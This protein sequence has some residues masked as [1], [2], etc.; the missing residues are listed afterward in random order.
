MIKRRFLVSAAAAAL[1]CGFVQASYA[2]ASANAPVTPTAAATAAAAPVTAGIHAPTSEWAVGPISAAGGKGAGY[3]SM[4]NSYPTGQTVVFAS[5]NQGSNSIALDFHKNLFDEGTQYDVKARVGSVTR[6]LEALAA[7]NQVLVM[8]TGIDTVFYGAIAHKHNVVFT[9][10]KNNYGFELDVSAADALSALRHCS[11]SF[12]SGTA[13]NETTFPLGKVSEA[14]LAPTEEPAAGTD[15]EPAPAPKKHH[16][17]KSAAAKHRHHEEAVAAQQPETRITRETIV[18]QTAEE[19]PTPTQTDTVRDDIKSEIASELINLKPGQPMKDAT[20][21]A[22]TPSATAAQSVTPP[23]TLKPMETSNDLRNLLQA[24]HV[25]S[26]G[27]QIK[28]GNN[29]NALR[30]SSDD[31]FGSAEQQP[32][33]PGKTLTDM[34]SDYLGKT[35]ALCK[36]EFAQK[37]NDVKKAGK[38]DVLEADITCLDGQTNAAAAILFVGGQGK[39]SVIMQEGTIDQLT[40]AM[41]DRDQIISAAGK[42]VN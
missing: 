24:S 27:Q 22:A 38:V 20:P 29:G 31:L 4:K 12:Q 25:I 17:R 36:G 13:F 34:A 15:D 2:A 10:D 18:Q 7:T 23:V 5:D 19:A 26:T 14:A 32:L 37:M 8:Q 41:S 11:E 9:V 39:Y 6:H 40:T 33:P 42:A 35:A 30:W 21:A 16:G 1:L 3:C 28:V